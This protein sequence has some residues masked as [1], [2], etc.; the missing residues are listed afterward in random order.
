MQNNGVLECG[1][2]EIEADAV[3][4]SPAAVSRITLAANT[5]ATVARR[6]VGATTMGR[7]VTMI[8]IIDTIL[9][10]ITKSNNDD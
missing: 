4:P 1:K 5:M 2:D 3:A 10:V 8:I 6:R 7:H 9:T